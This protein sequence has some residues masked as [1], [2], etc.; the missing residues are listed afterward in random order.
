[1]DRNTAA[2]MVKG[3]LESYLQERGINTNRAFLCLNPEHSDNHPSM[4]F[5]RHKKQAHCFSCGA[6]YDTFDLIG[7]ETGYKGGELFSYT[8]GLYGLDVDGVKPFVPSGPMKPR[9]L[10][11]QAPKPDPEL[12]SYDFTAIIE[13]AHQDKRGEAYYK[14]RGLSDEII[15]RYKLGYTDTYNELL[16]DMPELQ[17]ESRKQNQYGYVL[18]Y[19]NNDGTCNYFIAEIR[20]RAAADDYNGKYRKMKASLEINGTEYQHPAHI[21]NERYIKENPPACVYVC[22]GLYDALSYEE[23]GAP[24]VAFIGTADR[25]FLKLCEKY[26]PNTHFIITLDNDGAGKTATDRVTAGLEA[27]GIRYTV[28]NPAGQY[29]DANEALQADRKGFIAAAREAMKAAQHEAPP[30]QAKGETMQEEA[31]QHTKMLQAADE[32]KEKRAGDNMGDVIEMK[33]AID[34]KKPE[35]K[36][37]D[38]NKEEEKELTEEEKRAQEEQRTGYTKYMASEYINFLFENAKTCPPAM[39]T[40]FEELDGA[41]DGGLYAGLYCVGAISSLGKTTFVLQIADQ[42]AKQGHDALIFSL[43]MSRYELIAKSISRTTLEIADNPRDAKGIKDISVWNRFNNLPQNDKTLIKRAG[44]EYGEYAENIRIIEGMGNVT[45]SKIKQA[46]ARHI[47]ERNKI[48]V[49]VIDYLQLIAPEEGQERA[50][51]KQVIDKAVMELKRISRDHK[52]PVIAISSLNRQSY[53]D[54]ANMA[55]FKESGAIEYSSDVLIGLQLKGVGPK[56]FDVDAAKAKNP[57][58]IELVVLKNRNGMAGGRLEYKYFTPFHCFKEIG[59]AKEKTGL[60]RI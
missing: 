19:L 28:A 46:V 5:D 54:E 13:A 24:A 57:R 17:S 12:K 29:K 43:E 52:T 18:P 14:S 49:V 20:D 26:K 58:E 16:K 27:L 1:M 10:K 38:D 45:V 32:Q 41:L 3:N 21:F 40:G 51:P 53:Q 60:K 22:E 15:S 2:A 4:R 9:P 7:I 30:L 8:Y 55:S 39:S 37:A 50:T 44:Y 59:P 42:V 34:L 36:K 47:Q 48:P 11:L 33:P 23:A 6:S 56:D 35:G 31:P 25:R